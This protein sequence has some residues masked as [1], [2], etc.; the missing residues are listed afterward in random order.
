M[1]LSLRVRFRLRHTGVIQD[2]LVEDILSVDRAHALEAFARVYGAMVATA[3]ELP[4]TAVD[5]VILEDEW[6][7][8]RM[9]GLGPVELAVPDTAEN[10][11]GQR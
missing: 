2:V 7:E 5:P 4:T 9:S 1:A 3:V 6:G 8:L 11:N 10:T